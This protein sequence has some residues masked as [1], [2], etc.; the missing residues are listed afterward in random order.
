MALKVSREKEGERVKI[1]GREIR[2]MKKPRHSNG[3]QILGGSETRRERGEKNEKE[4]M[5][6]EGKGRK[7]KR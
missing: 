2:G 4:K 7:V 3:K 1:K 5:K 6:T